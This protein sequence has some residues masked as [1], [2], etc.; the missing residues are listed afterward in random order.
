MTS[1]AILRRRKLLSDYLNV[2]ARSIQNLQRWG[3]GQSAHYFDSRSFSS[4]MNCICQDSDKRKDHDEVSPI[5]DGFSSFSGLGFFP[6]KCYNTTVFSYVNRRVDVI[7]STGMRLWPCSVRYASTATAKQPNLESDDEELITKKKSEASPE[8]CDQA[9]V[10]L[11]TAKAKVKAKRLQESQK[12]AKS[13]IQRVWATLLGIGPALR[14]VA[15]MSREDW[16]KKNLLT[17]NMSLHLL[18]N[19]TG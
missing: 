10:G 2:S 6:L 7:S 11:S 4:T 19:I 5:N 12:V 9:V 3:N 14:A 18:C 16:A 8:E 13:V 17:G 15:S 1:R